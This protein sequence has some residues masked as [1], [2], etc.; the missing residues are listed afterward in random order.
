VT[1][2]NGFEAIEQSDD[3]ERLVGL[4]MRE[5]ITQLRV[6]E[7]VELSIGARGYTRD[8]IFLVSRRDV[9]PIGC[10]HRSRSTK[11]ISKILQKWIFFTNEDFFNL[12]NPSSSLWIWKPN[13]FFLAHQLIDI[14]SQLL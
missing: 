1:N 11:K 3:D 7:C 4:V 12:E 13:F 9:G 14:K 10:Q 5:T 6:A 2:G 8:A